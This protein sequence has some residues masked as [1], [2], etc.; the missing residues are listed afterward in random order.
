M[1][2]WRRYRLWLAVFA[3]LVVTTGVVWLLVIWE[4]LEPLQSRYDRVQVGMTVDEAKTIMGA[5]WCE[6]HDVLATGKS[7][8]H[9]ETIRILVWEDDKNV[10]ALW[11]SRDDGQVF[12]KHR[13]VPSSSGGMFR[14]VL[15]LLRL[16]P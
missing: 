2:R 1:L 10:Y 11:C 9:P 16:A 7:G 12:E 5:W 8:H 14:R 15:R 13:G 3:L 4:G 6:E